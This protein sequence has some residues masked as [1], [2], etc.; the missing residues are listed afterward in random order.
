MC[1][2]GI[3]SN[4]NQIVGEHLFTGKGKKR[5]EGVRKGGRTEW[6]CRLRGGTGTGGSGVVDFVEFSRK[7][8]TI[9]QRTA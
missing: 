8:N 9:G 7:R 5:W 2:W 3:R 6:H 4:S 1:D